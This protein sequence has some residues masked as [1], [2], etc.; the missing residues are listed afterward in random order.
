M[1]KGFLDIN[2]CLN[3]LVTKIKQYYYY[4]H[5]NADQLSILVALL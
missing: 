4:A 5:T 1:Y 2:S 3:I